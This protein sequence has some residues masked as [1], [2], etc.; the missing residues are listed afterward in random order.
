MSETRNENC[1]EG[2]RTQ[3]NLIFAMMR[4]LATILDMAPD[5]EMACATIISMAQGVS[6]QADVLCHDVGNYISELAEG[7]QHADTE[8]ESR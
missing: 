4:L 6:E 2:I 8:I 3:L 7:Y 1:K 5:N